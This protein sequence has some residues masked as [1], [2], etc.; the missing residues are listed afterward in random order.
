M[1]VPDAQ[2]L[3]E[4]I[5]VHVKKIATKKATTFARVHSTLR[6]ISIAQSK[7][8]DFENSLAVFREALAAQKKHFY[9]LEHLDKLPGKISHCVL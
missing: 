5:V 3:V 6:Q 2:K 4:D 1:Q 9:E 7:I 8:R